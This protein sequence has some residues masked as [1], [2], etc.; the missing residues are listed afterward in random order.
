MKPTLEAQVQ[1]LTDIEDIK[2]LKLHYARFCDDN[3]HPDGI[4]SC[5]TE[6]GI[7]DGGAMGYAE[8]RTAIHEYFTNSPSIVA[9]ATHYTTNP[10]IEVSGDSADGTWYLWQP[11]VM[12]EGEQAMWLGAHYEEQYVRQNDVW[13]IHRLKLHIKQFAPYEA[14]FGKTRIAEINI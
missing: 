12:V 8:G 6:D 10:I 11:M 13:L 4:T 7:W 3:Y 5:F 1:R 2:I 14:G 9:F